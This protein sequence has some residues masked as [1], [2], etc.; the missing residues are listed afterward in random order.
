MAI[1]IFIPFAAAGG[2]SEAAGRVIEKKILTKNKL[3]IKAYITYGFLV[4]SLIMVP[5]L[6]FFWNV[7]L[8]ALT[9]KNLFL[10][11][12]VVIAS[13]IA[14][15]FVFFSLKGEKLSELE[16]TYILQPLFLIILALTIYSSERQIAPQI[17][18]AAFIAAIALIGSHIKKHH[19]QFNKFLIAGVLGS[20]FHALELVISRSLLDIYNPLSFYFV[21]SALV[22]LAAFII[23]RPSPKTINKKTWLLIFITGAIWVFY[24]VLLYFGFINYGVIFTTLLFIIAPVFIYLFSAIFLKEKVTMR[25]I[26]AA[27]IILASI[28]YAITI[29][30]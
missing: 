13:V 5:L 14:N 8:E 21:R 10:L 3:D 17:L 9:P 2:I 29:Q 23:F 20:F 30:N 24:R 16:P 25:N 1:P 11:A 7:S 26:I 4:L 19:L 12:L 18:I 28:T 15:L 22:F 27:I 6:F